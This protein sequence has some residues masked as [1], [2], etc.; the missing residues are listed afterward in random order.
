MINT[1]IIIC[2]DFETNALENAYPLEIA[3]LAIDPRSLEII[4]N[5]KFTTLCKPPSN[6][7]IEDKALEINHIKR[8]DIE[9]APLLEVVWP[10]FVDWVAKFN[11]K[12]NKWEAPIAM[13]MNIK[14]FDLP[15]A[16]RMNELFCKKKQ[17]TV[18]FNTFKIIDLLDII[19]L[20]FENSNELTNSKLDTL[21][22][23]FGLSKNGSHR[24]LKDV[25]DTAAIAIRFLK[26]H[27]SLMSSGKVKFKDAFKNG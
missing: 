12:K 13:G 11:K 18:L 23:Y 16:Y 7:I 25:E 4:P 2:F 22:E 3:A 27:R 19:L 10:Q 17:D 15:I 8:E 1:N 26:F 21:R 6:V 5:E 24:A 14:S 20:W 9:K